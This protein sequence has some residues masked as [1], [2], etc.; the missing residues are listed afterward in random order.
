MATSPK[1]RGLR[2][3]TDIDRLAAEYRRNVD[4]MTGEYQKAFGEFEAG[5][6]KTL[7][8]YNLAMEQYRTQFADYEKQAAGYKQRLAA[9]QKAI[10]DFPTSAGEKANV[11]MSVVRGNKFFTID[12]TQYSAT[13][14]P[15][16]YFMADVMGE[17]PET[18]TVGAGRGARQVQTG[19]MI[20]KVVGQELRKRTPPGQFT[21]K[22]PT[23]PTAPTMPE[24]GTFDSSGFQKRRAEAE[25]AFQ[26]EVSERKAARLG[27]VSR[28][29]TRPMLQET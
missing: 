23:A 22:A 4:A 25:S 16:N 18:R 15:V 28:R 6:A 20:T 9:Y 27:A 13:D 1:G 29:A 2:R 3:M 19:N 5:R 12:G 11:P 7:E 17:V 21:E 8:P 10:E 26:R 14:L 24:L